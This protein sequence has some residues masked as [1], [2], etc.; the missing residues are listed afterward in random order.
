MKTTLEEI[1]EQYAKENK[2]DSYEQM[3]DAFLNHFKYSNSYAGKQKVFD[4]WNNH[5][6]KISKRHTSQQVKE[7]LERAAEKAETLTDDCI[8]GAV[9]KDLK[10][11]ILSLIKEYEV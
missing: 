5:Q 4:T 8:C 3:E 2:F 10:E 9:P 7:A 6:S 1:K 11:L